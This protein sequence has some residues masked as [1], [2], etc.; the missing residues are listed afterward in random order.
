M[1]NDGSQFTAAR[2][3]GAPARAQAATSI[4]NIK[5]TLCP[6]WFCIRNHRISRRLSS[7]L[8]DIRYCRGSVEA[9]HWNAVK[10]WTREMFDEWR[11]TGGWRIRSYVCPFLLVAILV[12]DNEA[13]SRRDLRRG[14]SRLR[15]C[16]RGPSFDL[17]RTTREPREAIENRRPIEY[18]GETYD[19][20]S[21]F[22]R[23]RGTS[24]RDNVPRGNRAL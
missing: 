21:R 22:P 20:L 3:H 15:H 9:S 7:R 6:A 14:I 11:K 5:V 4:V 2:E 8:N 24:Q 1:A 16:A 19:S 13:I 18:R 10:I 17:D 23:I 12:D